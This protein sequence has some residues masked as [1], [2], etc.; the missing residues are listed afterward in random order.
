ML[1]KGAKFEFLTMAA[2]NKL[3][4]RAKSEYLEKA[5]AAMIE[6]FGD[7]TE[8]SLF[9]DGPPTPPARRARK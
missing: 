7:F 1:L 6:E 2:F 4:R 9:K 8:Q 3:D 5:V